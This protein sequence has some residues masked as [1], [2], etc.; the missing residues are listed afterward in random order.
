[1]P[2]YDICLSRFAGNE[3][4]HLYSTRPNTNG[5]NLSLE[6]TDWDDL[7]A[8]WDYEEFTITPA[9]DGYRNGYSRSIPWNS[10]INF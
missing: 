9:S 5:V 4:L 6:M 1:M 2:G 8:D 3:F 10:M 7:Q